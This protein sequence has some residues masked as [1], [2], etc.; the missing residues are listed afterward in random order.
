M[1]A[2]EYLQQPYLL[3]KAINAKLAHYDQVKALA[4]KTTTTLTGMPGGGGVS[5]KVGDGVARMVE[6]SR[7]IDD[8]Q[9]QLVDKK[10]ELLAVVN[11]VDDGQCRRLLKL[12]FIHLKP[13]SYIV[14]KMG[15]SENHAKNRLLDKSLQKIQDIVD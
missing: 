4:T 6:I 5:D 10:A 14:E 11:K 8:L 9:D 7:E 15:I 13:W 12:L 2:K 3:D 1:T